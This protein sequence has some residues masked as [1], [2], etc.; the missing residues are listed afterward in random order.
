M[1]R[2]RNSNNR[3]LP[4]RSRWMNGAIRYQVPKGME[5]YWDN[6]K[7]F[8]LGYNIPEAFAEY[9]RRVGPVK[10]VYT[11]GDLLARYYIEVSGKK[12]PN[13]LKNDTKNYKQ[14]IKVF[15]AVRLEDLTPQH[16][17]QYIDYRD[18]KVSARREK[19]M[20]SHAFT[21]AVEWGYINK[22][23]FKGEVRLEGEKP[24]TR[25]VEDWEIQEI[26]ALKPKR[27]KDMTEFFQAYIGLKIL[28]GLRQGDLLKLP[29][30]RGHIGDRI[31]L[32]TGKR[33]KK[34]VIEITQA[35][36]E[37]MLACMKAR[38]VD[39][40][41]NL[42]CNR[43][44]NEYTGD[45]FRSCWQR[46]MKQRVMKETKITEWFTEHDIRAKAGSDAETDE[47]A[48]QLL[49]H[50]NVSTTKR[51]YRRQPTVIKSLK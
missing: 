4:P 22:H 14:L 11:I 46:F 39:I 8:T 20:L 19:A 5:K 10:N 51:A 2:Q 43:S 16:I 44:G 24:R 3:G 12:P 7:Q 25:Y 50:D 48:Q 27:A 40:A 6:K 41:P 32:V 45:G 1:P 33:S 17:Y 31:P 38:P 47:Q 23:P 37:A 49:T 29:A 30:Y 42:F 18:T 28:I 35:V 34:A 26:M 36:H 9:A 21:K 13:S 15:D